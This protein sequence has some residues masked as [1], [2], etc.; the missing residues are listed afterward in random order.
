LASWEVGDFVV[1]A[2]FPDVTADFFER[3]GAG[4]AI[5]AFVVSPLPKLAGFVFKEGAN[6][7]KKVIDY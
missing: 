2:K 4:L 3:V 6:F 5:A 7:V 1:F